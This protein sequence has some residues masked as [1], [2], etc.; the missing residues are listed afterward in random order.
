MF[1]LLKTRVNR[2]IEYGE[3]ALDANGFA[4]R[5]VSDH[6]MTNTI[7]MV[8]TIEGEAKSAKSPKQDL[9]GISSFFDVEF[10]RHGGLR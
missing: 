3:D 5:M 8:G 4:D 6:P 2:K 9:K 10:L 1:A 7:V